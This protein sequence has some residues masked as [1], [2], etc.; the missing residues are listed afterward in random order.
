MMMLLMMLL[1]MF[2]NVVVDADVEPTPPSPTHAITPPPPQQELIHSPSQ[3]E[4]TLPPSPHPSIIAQP[5]SPPPQQPPSH[6][7]AISMD[8]LNQLLETC[9]TLTKKVG[10]L[11]QDKIA[12]SI[13]IT[14]LKQRDDEAEPAKLKKVIEVV[15]TAKLIT[16]VVT[17]AGT[18]IIV[19]PMPEASA[20]RRRKGVVIR[21]PEETATLSVI[22]HSEPKEDLE[23]LWKIVQERFASSEL[24][25]FS[26]DFLMYT[27]KT[28]FEKPNVE[29]HVWK[30]KRGSYGLAKVKSWKLLESCGVHIITF[31]TTQ[32]ILPV[33]RRYPLTRFTLD[34]MLNNIPHRLFVHKQSFHLVVLDFIKGLRKKYRLNL[35]N[36]M[37]PR[38]KMENLNITMEEYIR[39][40]EEKARKRRKVFNLKTGKY[41]KI[42]I[43]FDEF[44]DRDYMVSFD[45]NSFSYKI[46]S[47]N[48]LKTDSKNDN[49]KV[50]MPLFPSP[51]PTNRMFEIYN[52]CTKLVDF[53]DMDFPTRDQRHRYFRFKGLQCTKGDIADFVMSLA[54]IYMRERRLFDIRGPLVHELILEFFSTFRFG[55]AVLN[56][57][58]ARALQ[59]QL[60]GARRHMSWRQFILAL[61]L[62][63]TW[64]W[65][66]SG[67]ERQPDVAGG[68][69]EAA[70]DASV[71]DEGALAIPAPVQAPQPP[72][73][74]VGPIQTMAQRLAR[75]EEDVHEIRGALGEQR[76][77]LD[78]MV[79]ISLDS[80]L[81]RTKT[82][83][84]F[85]LSSLDVLQGF[86]FFL[87][88]GLT[89]ILA[90]LDGLDVGLLED[91][92][93]E[94]DCDDDG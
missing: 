41:G 72:P 91:V 36:D 90:T 20:A 45:K 10:D 59:F 57:D 50:N 29:A 21:D 7:A 85:I 22:V 63:D 33:E 83:S 54:K 24:K 2:S 39:L 52:L 17:A 16:E 94:D 75:V 46:I 27:L 37:P 31:T 71:A 60:G 62:D 68:A 73:P 74:A 44:D 40:E 93:R 23:M 82:G 77:I 79:V 35:K 70:D 14:K 86:S 56:L 38:D 3:V 25:N 78:S 28:M 18:T 49:E 69:L 55:E 48:D 61:E 89:L 58:T 84:E 80:L 53:I 65:V 12:Q 88:M 8:L 30:S 6:D 64:A 76:E 9:A 47:A 51:E 32:M 34:Q 1:M 11:E 42:G 67:P 87:Q 92:I 5:S 19:A 81:G 66:A 13:E 15:T 43:S 26:D 4:S